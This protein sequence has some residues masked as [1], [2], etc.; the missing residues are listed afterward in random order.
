MKFSEFQM[1]SIGHRT[2]LTQGQ[3]DVT[4]IVAYDAEDRVVYFTSSG[5]DPRKKHL[6][7]YA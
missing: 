7:K 3:W 4:E 5:A 1:K 6:Y 2:Y